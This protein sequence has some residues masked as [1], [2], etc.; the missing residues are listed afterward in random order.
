MNRDTPKTE[1]SRQGL[2]LLGA[3]QPGPKRNRL[4][5]TD[6]YTHIH[7]Q[8]LYPAAF[9]SHFWL[10]LIRSYVPTHM[11]IYKLIYIHTLYRISVGSH[12]CRC[13][14][15]YLS[16]YLSLSIYLSIQMY[17]IWVNPTY[18]N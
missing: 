10:R 12:L 5:H 6:I 17:Y 3:P 4:I 11:Y 2:P 1:P 13:I 8:I 18:I 7:I 15:I 16:F 9:G 14:S